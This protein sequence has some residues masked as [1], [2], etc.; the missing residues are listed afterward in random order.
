MED[1]GSGRLLGI[2]NLTHNQGGRR[3]TIPVGLGGAA[4][5]ESNV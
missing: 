2:G 5:S 1:P 4:H 3:P